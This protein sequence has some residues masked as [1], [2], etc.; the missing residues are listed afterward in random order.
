[1]RLTLGSLGRAAAISAAFVMCLAT[2]APADSGGSPTPSHGGTPAGE[3][4]ISAN[5]EDGTT[6]GWV[7]RDNGTGA[8][9]LLMATDMG[10]DGMWAVAVADRTSQGSGVGLDV[11]GLLSPGVTYSLSARLRFVAGEA[12]ADI[13]LTLASDTGGS[14]AFATLAQFTGLTN[15]GW[16]DVSGSFTVSKADRSFLYFETKYEGAGVA[17]NTSS[18][19]VDDIAVS[20]PQEAAPQALAP[21]KDAVDFPLGVA[22]DS[23]ETMGA[24]S[25]LLLENFT[26]VTP[27]NFMKPE[28]WYDSDRQFAPSP[29]IA[30]LMDFA[31]SNDLRVYGHVLVWHQQTPGW[32][33]ERSAGVSLTSSPA[34]QQVLKDRLRAHIFGVAKYL[35]DRWGAFG[36][37]NPVVAFDVVN[38]AIDDGTAY[39]DGL[40]RTP[41]YNVLGEQYIDLAFHYADEAFNTTYAAP[42][43]DRPVKLFINDYNTELP[44]KRARYLA[45]VD[46]LLTRGVPV[47]GIGHQFHVTS[48]TTVDDLARA[49]DDASGRGLVQAVTEM[50]VPTGVPVTDARLL[51]QGYFFRDAFRVFRA[52][53]DELFSVTV[54]G[55]DDARSWRYA[56]GAPL[57]FDAALRAKPAYFGIVDG[58]GGEPRLEQPATGDSSGGAPWLPL[59]AVAAL[60]ACGVWVWWRRRSGAPVFSRA[61]RSESG[62]GDSRDALTILS[63]SLNPH[64]VPRRPVDGL[65]PDAVDRDDANPGKVEPPRD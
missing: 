65:G 13:W 8:P 2:T 7:P 22:I 57:I 3:A 20:A 49:L 28:A 10:Q 63:A 42:G 15:T 64:A 47:D 25:K 34:D 46:R 32:F 16:T 51:R 21:L 24:A 30:S 17:G 38:E 50:D 44:A 53:A 23:R 11:T 29:E 39:D 12:P 41:W 62:P 5:F 40:R 43:A 58:Y 54:W 14:Q 26:Q 48:P 36:G 9:H 18:F 45:L 31:A 33:F 56:Q 59:V 19:L 4:I 61:R 35:S 6:D 60:L 37:S 1:M 27:E 52:R 55:L